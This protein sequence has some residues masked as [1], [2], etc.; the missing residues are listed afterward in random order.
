MT[1]LKALLALILLAVTPLMLDGQARKK[2]AGKKKAGDNPEGPVVLN[3]APAKIAGEI[4]GDR[5]SDP[6][7]TRETFVISLAHTQDLVPG[8]FRSP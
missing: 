4:P 7:I 5:V 6:A 2:G 8:V 3:L 1:K